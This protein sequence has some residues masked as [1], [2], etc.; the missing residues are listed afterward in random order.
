MQF[1]VGFVFVWRLQPAVFS[2]DSRLCVQGFLLIV[3]EDQEVSGIKWGFLYA[4]QSMH[5]PPL[6]CQAPK[7]F[8]SYKRESKS[9]LFKLWHKA[10][11]IILHKKW[12]W[13]FETLRYFSFI[14]KNLVI[15][16]PLVTNFMT[17]RHSFCIPPS[18]KRL[19]NLFLLV[20]SFHYK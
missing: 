19:N 2:G 8:F 5:L 13:P 12:C 20:V 6:N 14:L 18:N 10:F 11:L 3:L 1:F 15:S 17:D 7:P 4:K 16:L 9:W